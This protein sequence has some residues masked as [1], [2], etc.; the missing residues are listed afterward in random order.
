MQ[1]F[2]LTNES[3]GLGLSC[4]CAGVSLAGVPLLR[5]TEAGF[6][7]RP[8]SDL[9]LLIEAAY[10]PDPT[11]LRSSLGIIAGALNAGNLTRATMAAA[12][13]RTPKL[14]WDEAVRLANAEERLTKYDP[15]E[16]RDWHG[17]WTMDGASIAAPA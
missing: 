13:T 12:L 4:T 5:K 14:S 2:R 10:G 3:G 11:R 15:D 9:A 16:R 6:E 8:A 17:R 7:P 1:T